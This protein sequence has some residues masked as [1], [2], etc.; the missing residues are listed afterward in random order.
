MFCKC[1]C[2]Y[3]SN[4]VTSI[5]CPRSCIVTFDFFVTELQ[6]SE[7]KHNWSNQT[8]VFSPDLYYKV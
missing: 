2:K 6:N 7:L 4:E 3:K 8:Q 1:G 5:L